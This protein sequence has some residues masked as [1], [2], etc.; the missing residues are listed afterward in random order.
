MVLYQYMDMSDAAEFH[1]EEP[2]E[3][4]LN[5][6]CRSANVPGFPILLIIVTMNMKMIAAGLSME[7]GYAVS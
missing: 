7:T 2:A 5:S 1:K 6:C 3:A 4:G